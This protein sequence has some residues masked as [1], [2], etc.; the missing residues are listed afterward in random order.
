MYNIYN[1]GP[2]IL[3]YIDSLA[4]HV[5]VEIQIDKQTID[6]QIDKMKERKEGRK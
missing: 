4:K 3:V 1:E 5:C 6:R 2:W